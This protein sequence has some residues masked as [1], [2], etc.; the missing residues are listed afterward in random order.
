MLGYDYFGRNIAGIPKPSSLS[1]CFVS[2]SVTGVEDRGIICKSLDQELKPT[3]FTISYQGAKSTLSRH[4][5]ELLGI[6][7]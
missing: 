2:F 4:V 7:S 5:L 3:L 1:E 6:D